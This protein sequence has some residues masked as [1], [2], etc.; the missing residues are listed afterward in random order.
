MKA[1]LLERENELIKVHDL[2]MLAKKINV[3]SSMVEHAKELTLA[4]TY[5]RYPD[6]PEIKDLKGKARAFLG[7]AEKVIEWTRKSLRS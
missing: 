2:V 7:Y 4:Y 6:M 3:P 1:L 5:T